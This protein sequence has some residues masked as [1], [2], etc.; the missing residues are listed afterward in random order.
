[1]SR[2]GIVLGTAMLALAWQAAAMLVQ[3]DILPGPC[4]V[5]RAFWTALPAGLCRHI[6]A[7]CFR[8]CAA[9]VVAVV[10]AFPFG[11]ALGQSRRLSRLL[12]P[13]VY[14]TYPVPKVVLLPVVVLFFGAGDLS[15]VLVIALIL[16][17]QMMVVVRDAAAS[18]RPELVYS[19]RSLGA[20]TLD[21][22]R[23]VYLPSCLPAALTSL[24][25]GTGTAIAVL[26]FAESFATTSGLGY[27]IMVEGWGRLAY[28]EMYA[29]V[30]AMSILGLAIYLALDRLERLAC[31]W[32][33]VN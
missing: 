25:V 19:V 31:P 10:S 26:F 32:M 9:M 2:R 33:F 7:S 6:A 15:K 4:E 20:G 22:L 30:M 27:Y 1:V 28:P 17:Y 29:G 14:L 11:L 8:V 21:L 16:F 5:A 3:R 12:S 24:R 18:V 23:Y 13:L